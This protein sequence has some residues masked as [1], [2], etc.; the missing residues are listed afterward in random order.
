MGCYSSVLCYGVDADA[1]GKWVVSGAIVSRMQ[2]RQLHSAC[3]RWARARR[4]RNS[5]VLFTER[6][7]TVAAVYARNGACAGLATVVERKG[8]RLMQPT[9][10]RQQARFETIPQDFRFR[11][12]WLGCLRRNI[13]RD[14]ASSSIN[15]C[16][17][18][19][20]VPFGSVSSQQA[21]PG[22]MRAAGKK[23]AAEGGRP[24]AA[25][26]CG[27]RAHDASAAA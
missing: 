24:T 17:E 23:A 14:R 6:Q 16:P 12:G 18:A 20:R 13:A 19:C 5:A 7:Q 11:Q 1:G 3:G 15:H 27:H 4:T 10:L 25:A 9:G 8:G 26:R 21:E 22:G 2:S